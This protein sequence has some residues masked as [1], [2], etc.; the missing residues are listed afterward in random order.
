LKPTSSTIT[1][2]L[3]RP[4]KAAEG[5]VSHGPAF[6]VAKIE[7]VESSSVGE[8]HPHALTD[9]YMTLSAHTAPIDQ[10]EFHGLAL[11]NGSSHFWLT[12]K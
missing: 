10:P 12:I 9:P 3:T 4:L 6:F 8:S 1:K 11:F 5:K 2:Q 7:L